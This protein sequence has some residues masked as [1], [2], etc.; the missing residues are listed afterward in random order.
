LAAAGATLGTSVASM[1]NMFNP[2][3]LIFT[4][5]AVT[6][7]GAGKLVLFS[8]EYDGALH[9]HLG[10]HAY[11]SAAEDCEIIVVEPG[12]H[13]ARGAATTVIHQLIA[14]TIELPA[15]S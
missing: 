5:P 9:H 12:W 8:D 2:A 6:R 15:K 1:L 7:N 11:S 13:G 4:G 3:R 14:G 10:R